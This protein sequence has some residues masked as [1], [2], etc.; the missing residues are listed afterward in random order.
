MLKMNSRLRKIIFLFTVVLIAAAACVAQPAVRSAPKPFTAGETLVYDGK[1]S[2]IIQG[3]SIAELK[4]TVL[5][6]PDP[7]DLLIKT[8]AVSKGTLLKLFRFSFLQQYESLVDGET[9]HI[10]KTTKHDVQKERVRDSE[11]AFDYVDGR[12]RYVETDPKDPN[13]PPR[14][15]A[16]EIEAEMND[17]VSGIYAIRL[18]P[19]SI[20][21][22]FEIPISDS[23]LVYRIP[24]HVTAR[25]QVKTVL[26]K[27]W[28][29]RVEPL[30]FGHDRLIE[31]KGGMIIWYT[32]DARRLPVRGRINTE[33]GK[34]E[35]KL[36]SATPAEQ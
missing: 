28:C 34:I 25:E 12:V 36:R 17:I 7:D 11:A 20:G 6:A 16:S 1:L 8:E 19:L 29:Y 14:R 10:L 22:K 21:K 15:I 26:G 2:K 30:I 27:V 32:D 23:G 4:F 3:L 31:Q 24:V 13:R 9:F 33:Y 35:V 5:E 18:M